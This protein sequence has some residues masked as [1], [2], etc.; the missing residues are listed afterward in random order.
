MSMAHTYEEL[1]KMTVAQLREV[2]KGIEHKAVQ[3]YTQLHKEQLLLAIC[4]ALG[5]DPHE[6]HEV[7]GINKSKVKAQIK[8]LKAQ[9]AAATEAHD[10]KKLKEIRREIHGLKRRLRKATV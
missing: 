3:G 7:V 1:H 4:A 6:H 8:K 5:V 2:A 10:K 9:R